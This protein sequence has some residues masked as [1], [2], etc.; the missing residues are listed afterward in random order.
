MDKALVLALLESAVE[1]GIPAIKKA[2]ES[3]QKDEITLEDIQ[4]LKTAIKRPEEY[5]K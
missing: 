4:S 3:Y 5:F 2:V 1:H